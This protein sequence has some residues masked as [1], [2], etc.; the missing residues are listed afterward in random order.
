MKESMR[1]NNLNLFENDNQ[2]EAEKTIIEI[3]NDVY[4]SLDL[5]PMSKTVFFIS[6]ALLVMSRFKVKN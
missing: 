4:T 6:R 3:S 1:S 2:I 5:K